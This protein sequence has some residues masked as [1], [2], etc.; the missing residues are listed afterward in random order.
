MAFDYNVKH[1]FTDGN[2]RVVEGEFSNASSGT[3]G[4]IKTGLSVI[5][6]ARFQVYG[7]AVVN[8]EC[9]ATLT[10]PQNSGNLAFK[11]TDQAN[12]WWQAIGY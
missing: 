4:T 5:S 11:C 2:R 9:A 6:N 12:G 3:G 7:A 8:D 10:I 1:Q